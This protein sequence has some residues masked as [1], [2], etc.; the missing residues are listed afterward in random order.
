MI[1][2]KKKRKRNIYDLYIEMQKENY[3]DEEKRISYIDDGTITL[4]KH[5]KMRLEEQ[6]NLLSIKGIDRVDIKQ[7]KGKHSI[8]CIHYIKNMCMK[9]LFCNYLHQ[10][11]Y[12]RIPTCK[13]YMKYNY[14]ADRVRGCCMFRHTLDNSNNNLYYNESKDEYLDDALKFLHEKNIC[15]NYLL[16]FCSLG[17]GCRKIHKTKSRRYINIISTLP[18]FF[19]D[20]ILVNKHLYTHLY[21]NPKKLSNDM[22]KLKDALI[23]LSGEKYI[24][25]NLSTNKNDNIVDLLNKDVIQNNNIFNSNNIDIGIENNISHGDINNDSKNQKGVSFLPGYNNVDNKNNK[26]INEY[27]D[28]KNIINNKSSHTNNEKGYFHNNILLQS[29]DNNNNNN[30]IQENN[31]NIP[32]VYD[33]NNNLIVAEKMK[34][35]IIKCNQISHLYLSILYG[36][37]ATGKNNTRKF[38]N[39]FKDNYTIIFLFSVNESGGFQG[40]A[41]MVTMPIKNLYENLWGPITSRLGGNFR[42]QWIKMAKID[43]DNFKHIV[44]PYND[45]LPLKKSRDGTELPLNVA[46]ILCNKMNDMPNEDFLT[47]TIY[48]FKRRINHSSFFI[49]LHKQ[50]IL[51]TN[52][53]WDILIFNLN[54]KSD[55]TNITLIDGTEQNI[56]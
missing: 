53:R 55:C 10:L 38:V 37:W 33:L 9:N 5:V 48:E 2:N 7:K 4:E 22:N 18:K 44:N 54:Q 50:N 6:T 1:R 14:C 47:G 40:Y 16:G 24:D 32:N 3:E 51:N 35:F 17:Y 25:K 23:I 45:N 43:F 28:D 26:Y 36:V 34:V 56:T 49:N 13:N 42:I 27:I 11:I 19:L 30:L 31:I 20:S 12:S 39:L 46:S 41:K 8:I 29:I 21:N 15:V 52:T